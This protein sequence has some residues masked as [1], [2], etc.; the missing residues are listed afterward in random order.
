MPAIQIKTNS[1]FSQ[2]NKLIN[3]IGTL[4]WKKQ[5]FRSVGKI[6]L[7]R[8]QVLRRAMLFNGKP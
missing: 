7:P 6:Q 1:N 8:L 2:M 3:L 4:R 5:L